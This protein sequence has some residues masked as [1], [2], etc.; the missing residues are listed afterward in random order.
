MTFGAGGHT[1][2]IL[3]Q[4]PECKIFCLDRDP[5]AFKLAEELASQM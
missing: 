5:E 1:K 4:A 2:A 3:E